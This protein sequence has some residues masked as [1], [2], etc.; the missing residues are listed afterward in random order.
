[1]ERKR[2]RNERHANDAGVRARKTRFEAC[3]NATET[4]PMGG[5][6][7][8]FKN[9]RIIKYEVLSRRERVESGMF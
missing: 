5:G 2:K 6:A 3:V 1:M 7:Y 8:P 4:T 9:D